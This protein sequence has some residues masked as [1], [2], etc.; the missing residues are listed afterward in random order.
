MR[1]ESD[2]R[3]VAH[4]AD[5]VVFYA[6]SARHAGTLGDVI[7]ATAPASVPDTA[8]F[9]PRH[10][11]WSISVTRT[12]SY[13][14]TVMDNRNGFGFTV[15]LLIQAPASIGTSDLDPRLVLETFVSCGRIVAQ[16][17]LRDNCD[18]TIVSRVFSA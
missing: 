12:K 8:L 9:T 17:L 1:N 15:K 13:Y 7:A 16:L 10:R 3:L 2:R 11:R 14:F 4:T 6:G 18:R 5:S